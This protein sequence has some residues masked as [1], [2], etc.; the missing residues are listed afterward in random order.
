MTYLE[1]GEERNG[2]WSVSEDRVKKKP[3]K[4]VPVK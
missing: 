4:K 2:V 1:R 3:H